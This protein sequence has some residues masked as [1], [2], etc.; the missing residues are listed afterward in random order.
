ML[1]KQPLWGKQTGTVERANKE[2]ST[3]CR[4]YFYNG[5]LD[6]WECTDPQL[7][8]WSHLQTLQTLQM[9]IRCLKM[10]FRWHPMEFRKTLLSHDWSRH[11]RELTI[12]LKGCLFLFRK[13]T[14]M[15]KKIQNR[16]F[17]F[18]PFL[19]GKKTTPHL[20]MSA[21]KQLKIISIQLKKLSI[22]N[23]TVLLGRTNQYM[24]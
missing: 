18:R 22:R 5:C 20:P 4:L 10:T 21:I 6:A 1:L 15:K 12:N 24:T 7:T 16:I 9:G 11:P 13:V 14:K 3:R 8:T 23:P 2:V 19:I 17:C